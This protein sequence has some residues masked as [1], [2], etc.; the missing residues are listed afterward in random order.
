MIFLFLGNYNLSVLWINYNFQLLARATGLYY[1]AVG[2][3]R[4]S[5]FFIY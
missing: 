3:M 1:K 5:E 4:R 2:D